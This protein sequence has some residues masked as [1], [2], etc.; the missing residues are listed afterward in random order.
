MTLIIFDIG[1]VG[2][3]QLGEHEDYDN[4]SIDILVK[5][6]STEKLQLL[7]GHRQSG[8]VNIKRNY[9]LF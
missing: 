3:V 1:C 7:T 5:F 6:R 8:G 9:A 4:W 2:E